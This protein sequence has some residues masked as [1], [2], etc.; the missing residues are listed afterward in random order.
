MIMIFPACF[1]PPR[2]PGH[3]APAPSAATLPVPPVV[4]GALRVLACG[5]RDAALS[6]LAAAPTVSRGTSRL[7]S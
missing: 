4:R 1:N 7:A 2:L 5:V 3:G 6:T